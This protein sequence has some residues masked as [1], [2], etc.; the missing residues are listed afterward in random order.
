MFEMVYDFEVMYNASKN[1][2]LFHIY[3]R[4]Q[5]IQKMSN[6]ISKSCAQFNKHEMQFTIRVSLIFQ[7]LGHRAYHCFISAKVETMCGRCVN[8]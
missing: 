2:D 1:I 6:S 4:Q 8:K 3:A 7:L 5:A